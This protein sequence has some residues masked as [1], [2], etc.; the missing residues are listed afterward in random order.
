MILT[1]VMNAA[2]NKDARKSKTSNADAGFPTINES[3]KNISSKLPNEMSG[4]VKVFQNAIRRTGL[5]R[6]IRLEKEA[7]KQR[8]SELIYGTTDMK[9]RLFER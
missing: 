1:A 6:N 3:G 2:A 4:G 8:R 7:I 5:V 9:T